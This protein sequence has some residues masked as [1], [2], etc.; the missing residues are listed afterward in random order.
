MTYRQSFE[1]TRTATLTTL[2]QTGKSFDLMFGHFAKGLQY[3]VVFGVHLIVLS[4][5]TLCTLILAVLVFVHAEADKFGV[6]SR[7]E[8]AQEVRA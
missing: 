4:L 8:E 2:R 6:R 7:R 1:T 3:A 5:Q